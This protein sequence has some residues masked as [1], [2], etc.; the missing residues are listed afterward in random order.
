MTLELF[1]KEMTARLSE[2]RGRPRPS[3]LDWPEG[4][5][6]SAKSILLFVGPSPGGKGNPRH[7]R[8]LWDEAFSEPYDDSPDGWGRKYRYSIPTYLKIILALRLDEAARLYGFANFDS[9]PSPT[10]SAVSAERMTAGEEHVLSVL[11]SCRPHLVV[12]LTKGAARRLQRLLAKSYKPIAPQQCDVLI[13]VSPRSFHRELEVYRLEGDGALNGCVV[14]RSPQHPNRVLNP[15]H[16]ERCARAIRGAFEQ[17]LAGS[18]TV[19]IREVGALPNHGV[20]T[21]GPQGACG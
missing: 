14:I 16:A 15:D 9:V 11:F 13:R 7:G 19:T 3:N 1:S 12:P 21:D 4:C 8:A 2:M 18:D 5:Y 17:M 20:Q 6:G 10:E